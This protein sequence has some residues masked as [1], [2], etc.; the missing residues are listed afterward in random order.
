MVSGLTRLRV[1]TKAT[2]V[3]LAVPTYTEDRTYTYEGV[4]DELRVSKA[5]KRQ[6]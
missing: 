6:S 1:E 5:D 4:V 2:A 3:T